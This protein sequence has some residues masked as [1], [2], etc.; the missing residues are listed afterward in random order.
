[1]EPFEQLKDLA[2]IFLPDT[3][4]VVRYLDVYHCCR[5]FRSGFDVYDGPVSS[6]LKLDAVCNEVLKQATQLHPVSDDVGERS[7][8]YIRAGMFDLSFEI[9]QQFRNQVVEVD[10]VFRGS[11]PQDSGILQNV[12][13]LI[14]HAAGSLPALLKQQLAFFVHA[15]AFE[16]QFVQ[17][18]VECAR[19]RFQ[20]VRDRIGEFALLAIYLID[21]QQGRL[22]L[23]GV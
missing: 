16:F 22:H 19:G 9:I 4:P 8:R 7:K 10:A 3:D 17:Q 21:M 2:L 23:Y 18:Q 13:H 5:G 20:I 14:H 12:C 11:G 15:C 1:M 6:R